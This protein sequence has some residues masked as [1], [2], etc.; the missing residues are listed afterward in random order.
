MPSRP[1][2]T[3]SRRVSSSLL[4]S[5]APVNTPKIK[6]PQTSYR[7]MPANNMLSGGSVLRQGSLNGIR[8]RLGP[9]EG[10]PS[11]QKQVRAVKLVTADR[12]QPVSDSRAFVEFQSFARNF[13]QPIHRVNIRRDNV[14]PSRS[15]EPQRFLV[16]KELFQSQD[17][18]AISV[19]DLKPKPSPLMLH[20]PPPRIQR[21]AVAPSTF[22]PMTLR[23]PLTEED[24]AVS[25]LLSTLQQPDSELSGTE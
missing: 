22:T 11:M 23:R 16:K 25:S 5:R 24:A 8:K 21:I 2:S 17:V 14:L 10:S 6:A 7:L 9:F 19:E 4:V 1:Y 12:A 20:T 18:T 13:T 15:L 3:L